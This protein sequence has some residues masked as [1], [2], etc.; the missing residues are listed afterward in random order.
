VRGLLTSAGTM[1]YTFMLLLLLLYV[2]ACLGLELITKNKNLTEDEQLGAIVSER[3]SSISVIMLTLVQLV[4]LDD[5]SEMYTPF[6]K[7]S[8]FLLGSYFMVFI[9][10]VSISLMNLVTAVIVEGAIEQ[11]KHDREVQKA[12][13]NQKIAALIPTIKRLFCELDT[14]GS[15]ELSLDEI[16]GADEGVRAE[17]QKILNI[18]DIAT[19]VELVD[20][21][22]GEINIDDFCNAVTK[23]ITSEEPI[24][25]VRLKQQMQLTRRESQD[26]GSRLLDIFD[27]VAQLR[28]NVVKHD[29]LIVGLTEQQ[30][31][32]QDE[33]GLRIARIEA[34]L[35][36]VAVQQK[37][38][39]DEQGSRIARMEATLKQVAAHIL[40]TS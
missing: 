6:V 22:S 36:Q 27:A 35:Q 30:E 29:E 37:K 34:T 31:K 20:G 4:T 17:L 8:P 33:Q 10:V 12:Y 26:V 2:F 5:A 15:G 11:S 32:K 40:G 39:Q 18:D 25:F 19:L 28:D 14:D 13:D 3:F 1:V 24:E 7:H 38:Q 9:I 16:N 23:T 21:G